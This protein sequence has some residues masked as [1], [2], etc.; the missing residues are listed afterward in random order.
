MSLTKINLIKCKRFGKK[1]ASLNR[2]LWSSQA[3]F[4]LYSGICSDCM[5]REEKGQ[6]DLAQKN[7]V[8]SRLGGK[9]A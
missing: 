5:T 8:K 4:D 2:P 3:T 7:D 1:I 9:T 6:L